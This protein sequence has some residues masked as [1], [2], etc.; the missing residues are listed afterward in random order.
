MKPINTFKKLTGYFGINNIFIG[1]SYSYSQEL[2]IEWNKKDIDI[3]ILI[4]RMESWAL[5]NILELVFDYVH[6]F[7]HDFNINNEKAWKNRCLYYKIAKQW[8][9]VIG[10]KDG[11][12]Y[13]LIFIDGDINTLLDNTGSSISKIYHKLKY[14]SNDLHLIPESKLSISLMKLRKYC[15]ID[16]EQCTDDYA[17]KIINICNTLGYKYGK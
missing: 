6:V 4:P 14:C 12:M 16:M 5:V 15:K 17:S 1:G 13:D 8:K 2:N 11:M 7:D 10:Y 3:F 9:R